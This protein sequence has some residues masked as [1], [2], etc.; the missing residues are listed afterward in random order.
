MNLNME[1]LRVVITA[2]AGGIGRAAAE[3]FLREGARV[4]VCDMSQTALD[5]LA[6]AKPEIGSCQCDVS[7]KESVALM[8]DRAV[9]FLGGLDCLVNNAGGTGPTM[10]TADIAAEDWAR[11]VDV[12]LTGTFYCTNRAI[13]HLRESKN[14]S[15]ISMSSAAG[16]LGY[17]NKSPYAAAKW[18]IVGFMKT[19]SIEYGVL[20]IRCNAVLP[21][22][23][24]N[25]RMKEV[26]AEKAR[27]SGI[28]NAEQEK[29]YLSLAS[30]KTFVKPDEVADLIVFLSSERARSISGQ[31]IGIDGDLQ[32]L[33]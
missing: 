7:N 33:V 4:F 30:L 17:P 21:G 26:I 27:L 29:R 31:A 15:I 11:C 25:A 16:R 5:A 1:G 23:V 18:G 24:D 19:V 2:G 10:P 8:I 13:P 28:S 3:A 6:F 9:E 20:G 32:A 22:P 12:N 14:A